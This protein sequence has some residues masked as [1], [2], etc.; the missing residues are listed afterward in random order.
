MADFHKKITQ[1]DSEENRT[2]KV[3]EVG[4][5]EDLARLEFCI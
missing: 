3:P 2:L 1:C 5:G 4:E